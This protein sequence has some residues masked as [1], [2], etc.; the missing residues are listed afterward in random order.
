MSSLCLGK[1]DRRQSGS[2]EGC[3]RQGSKSANVS[4]LVDKWGKGR[5]AIYMG[6]RSHI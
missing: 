3:R 5:I 2:G 1:G 4:M 6:E